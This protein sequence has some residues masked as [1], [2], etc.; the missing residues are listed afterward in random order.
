MACAGSKV[1]LFRGCSKEDKMIL[2]KP[3][4]EYPMEVAGNNASG[5]FSL[6]INPDMISPG[7]EPKFQRVC[8]ALIKHL[9]H[10]IGWSNCLVLEVKLSPNHHSRC[11]D[12]SWK[13]ER[14]PGGEY[15]PTAFHLLIE[16]A[17]P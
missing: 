7:N 2:G 10:N 15:E 16:A 6:D 3:I 17:K 9:C 8:A 12:V 13:A 4:W 5:H 14:V 11:V 1:P